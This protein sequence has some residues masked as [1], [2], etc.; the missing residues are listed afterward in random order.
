MGL[1]KLTLKTS[2]VCFV[3]LLTCVNSFSAL[4]YQI[5]PLSCR[6]D[7][8]MEITASADS[9]ASMWLGQNYE[10]GETVTQDDRLAFEWYCNAAMQSDAAGQFKVALFLLEGKGSQKDLSS[11][12]E[13][14]NRA[15]N[16]GSHNAEFALGILLVETDAIRSAV[17]FKRAAEAGNLYANHRLAELYYYGMGVPQNYAKAKELSEAGV[18]AGFEKSK[19]LL[20]RIRMKQAPMTIQADESESSDT[21]L[22]PESNAES[23][24]E[25]GLFQSFV[26]MLPSIFSFKTTERMTPS[27]VAVTTSE[28]VVSSQINDVTD[29][30]SLATDNLSRSKQELVSEQAA[31]VKT[32]ASII[33]TTDSSDVQ[34]TTA[35]GIDW[36][37]QQPEMSYTIQLVQSAN[38]DRINEFI[39]KYKLDNNAY[40]ISALQDDQNRYILLYGNYPNISTTKQ[41]IKT[42]SSGIQ[43]SDYWIRT[44]GDLRRSYK[45]IH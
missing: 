12:I 40:Y 26:S 3:A 35:R 34:S 28:D 32:P 7:N 37:N 42:L 44:F 11:G 19:E 38:L 23:Q 45:I 24:Q 10:F 39:K 5:K 30:P 9:V 2:L 13:W 17:L 8:S 22:T 41:V 15:V 36:I 6:A 25:I 31:L 29:T 43:E 18:A 16:N 33:N 20:I 4:S 14:L 21:S 1:V 27:E